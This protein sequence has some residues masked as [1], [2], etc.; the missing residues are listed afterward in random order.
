MNIVRL[1][2]R[3]PNIL[4]I[5]VLLALVGGLLAM[6]RVPSATTEQRQYSRTIGELTEG[7]EVGQL[8]ESIRPHLSGV[9]FQVATYGGR[10]N[11]HGVIF[12]LRERIEDTEPLRRV[13]VNARE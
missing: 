2:R 7:R 8:F 6:W 12:E 10:E 3:L 4:G 13:T 11:T 5:V 1:S 9:A